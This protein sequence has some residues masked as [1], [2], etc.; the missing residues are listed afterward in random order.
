M[1]YTIRKF[2]PGQ[3]EVE[4]EDGSWAMVPVNAGMTPEEV[5][6]EVAKY[7]PEF[8]VHLSTF[9][10][11]GLNTGE[12]RISHYQ[13]RPKINVDLKQPHEFTPED[14]E[15]VDASLYGG[16]PV[17][18]FHRDQAM[19]ALFMADYFEKEQNSTALRDALYERIRDYIIRHKIS[20]ERAIESLYF[21]ENDAIY[22]L[23][24]EQL[25]NE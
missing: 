20:E 9:E 18:A 5:D 8:L 19:M 10:A 17:P 13:E 16:L 7:D 1:K 22:R 15:P 14:L 6:I 23:A 11:I 2:H 24:L 21:D 12:V 3:L 25:E 4:Y